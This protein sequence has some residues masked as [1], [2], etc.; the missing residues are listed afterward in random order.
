[1]KYMMLAAAAGLTA[2]AGAPPNMAVA[3]APTRVVAIGTAA[4]G[5]L[6]PRDAM[7]TDTSYYQPW[8]FTGT[9]GQVVQIDM[10]STDFDAFLYLEDQNGNRLAT[11]DD[12]GGGT[13]AR[14][15]YTLPYTGTYRILAN[16]YRRGEKGRYTL[17]ITGLGAA[18]AT[19][20]TALLPG[21]RGQILRGQT[22]TGQLTNSDPKLAD[23]SPYQA[24]TYVGR[25]GEQIQVDVVSADFDAYAI[26]QDTN[27]NRLASDD[28]SGG[29]TNARIVYTLPYTGAYRL[30]ANTYRPNSYGA[31]TISVK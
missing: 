4:S 25:A 9:A 19:G 15:V 11:D 22:M 28:D 1:M 31:Y 17:R 13:N 29:G 18:S 14:I 20:G 8:A 5:E 3:P 23:G 7:L 26:I 2:C 24:W 10:T 6:T 12:S 30:I 16:A 27:G 21:T